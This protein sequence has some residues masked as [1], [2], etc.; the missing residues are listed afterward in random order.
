MDKGG[1][2]RLENKIVEVIR[3]ISV[4]A[5]VPEAVYGAMCH[6]IRAIVNAVQPEGK[7]LDRILVG[8]DKTETEHP[9]GWWETSAG[10]E[11]GAKKL[12]ELKALFSPLVPPEKSALN[13]AAAWPFPASKKDG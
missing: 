10:A 9:D 11:F 2:M 4:R 5:G 13:P 6:E 8:I 7:A 1:G 3:E 12:A